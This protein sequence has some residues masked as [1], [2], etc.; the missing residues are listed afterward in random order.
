MSSGSA[1][2]ASN[3]RFLGGHLHTQLRH[4]FLERGDA[5]ILQL[6]IAEAQSL[7]ERRKFIPEPAP[8]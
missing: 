1:L 3:R 7:I 5:P 2:R 8:P 4:L 6:V